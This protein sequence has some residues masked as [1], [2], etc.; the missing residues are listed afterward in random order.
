MVNSKSLW[1]SPA[2][3][4]MGQAKMGLHGSGFG[5]VKQNV[6]DGDTVN[7]SFFKNLG[8]RFLGMDTPEISFQLPGND[9]FI[10]LSKP[11]WTEFSPLDN[12]ASGSM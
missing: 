3:F 5:S 1:V 2:R 8:V 12:G 7:V 9:D 4:K 11:A 6:H 10:H